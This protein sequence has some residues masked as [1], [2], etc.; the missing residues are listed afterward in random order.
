[1]IDLQG[2]SHVWGAPEDERAYSLEGRGIAAAKESVVCR[3]CG[4]VID[5][6]PC[7]ACAHEP[8]MGGE[9]AEDVILSERMAAFKRQMQSGPEARHDVLRRKLAECA[10]KNRH[11][12]AIWHWFVS[13]FGVELEK[14]EYIR[15]LAD[16]TH[17]LNPKVSQW[18]NEQCARLRARRGRAA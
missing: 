15:A 11:P 4:A 18:A 14:R 2:I 7:P 16:L 12:G 3:V 5:A 13:A 10:H 8:E 17:D 9:R 6:Y 1:M